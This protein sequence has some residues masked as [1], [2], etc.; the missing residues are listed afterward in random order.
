IRAAGRYSER[1]SADPTARDGKERSSCGS[2]GRAAQEEIVAR[3][4]A[5]P[6]VGR[7]HGLMGGLERAADRRRRSDRDLVPAGAV[8]DTGAPPLLVEHP[9]DG[10]GRVSPPERSGLAGPPLRLDAQPGGPFL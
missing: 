6:P 4:S 2:P 3:G 9:S 7:V 5:A 1:A 10:A 8:S